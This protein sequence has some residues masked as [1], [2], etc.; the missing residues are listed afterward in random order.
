MID[1]PA[2]AE[3][4]SPP[5]RVN[6]PSDESEVDPRFMINP[7]TDPLKGVVGE[8]L[9]SPSGSAMQ[10]LDIVGQILDA[11][12]TNFPHQGNPVG[13]NVE[14]TRA[15]T[16]AN[17][18]KEPFLPTDHP[19]INANGELCDR[20]GSPLIFHQISKQHM[21]LRSAGPDRVPYSE[22]DLVWN[23]AEPF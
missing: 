6:P 7:D 17:R 20:W 16:G 15:L 18:L 11:W 22:D 10:D 14:I 8:G 23:E 12:Q 1:P 3:I 2:A 4:D 21:E 9:N 13:L 5:V 19:A